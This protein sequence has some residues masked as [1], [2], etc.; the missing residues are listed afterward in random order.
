MTFARAYKTYMAPILA[1]SLASRTA[2]YW[3]VAIAASATL[4][5][6]SSARRT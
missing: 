3:H 2:T 4:P 6:L 5:P 1:S